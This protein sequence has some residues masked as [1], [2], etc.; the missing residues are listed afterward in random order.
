[1]L[2]DH[3]DTNK[4]NHNNFITPFQRL[5][6]LLS[7]DRSDLI[8]LLVYTILSGSL[9]LIIPLTAK[10]LVNT[11]AA[12]VFV[13]PLAVLTLILFI[14]LLFVGAFRICQFYL[15]EVLQQRVFAKVAL[16]LAERVPSI[17]HKAWMDQYLPEV[18]NRFFDVVKVQKNLSKLLLEAPA[19]ILQILVG[20]ALMAIYSPVLFLFDLFIIGFVL[21]VAFI[22]GK[23]GV[24]TSIKESIEKYRVA[25]WLEELAR[26]HTSFKLDGVP[27]FFYNRTDEKVMDYLN[28]RQDH[29]RILFRQAI[30]NYFFQAVATAGI[31]GIGGWLVI[32]RQI[33]LGQLVASELVIL[34]LLAA[35]EKLITLFQDW[36][37][38]LTGL[39]KIGHIKD[40]PLE[41]KQGKDI[42]YNETGI[43]INCHGISFEY[44]GSREVLSNVNFNIEPGE[45]IS[46]AG[47]S[48]AGKSTLAAI[49]CGLLE[50]K[51]G[52]V[53]LN[54]MDVKSIGL[55]SLRGAVAMVSDNNEI[56]EG[57]IEE[58][59]LVGRENVTQQ[60][61]RWALEMTE[62]HTKIHELPNGLQT[63]LLS[64]G[65]SLSRG[66]KQKLLIA[67]GIVDHPKLLILDEAFT[68]IDESKKLRVIENLFSRN[69]NWTVIDISH[70]AEVVMRS[71]KIMVLMESQIIETGSPRKLI[72]NKNSAFAQ[73]FPDLSSRVEGRLM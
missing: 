36:Y 35:V 50:P 30:G 39:D 46:I 22:L 11:I 44:E 52:N 2:K 31:F 7:E 20:L 68:G 13:Q 64:S 69:N 28:S 59:I 19:A 26:C 56:F 45:I 3:N 33:T 47:P 43:A 62:L 14:V 1:M 49:L 63:R 37:D 42:P 71:H 15:V 27:K 58:N 61:I 53:E 24:S 32:D 72:Y 55:K 51:Q 18:L 54:G 66:Q 4:S 57:T 34:I 73:L 12:G 48:G 60:D 38:L 25:S 65:R 29:F 8:T 6:E 40:L 16:D 41:R 5:L 21:F 67:R 70:D 10:A 23:G 9:S 17:D